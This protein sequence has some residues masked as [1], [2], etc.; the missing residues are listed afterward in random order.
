MEENSDL[1]SGINLC[2]PNILSLS[3]NGGGHQLIAVLFAD[4]IRGLEK[5]GGTVAPRHSLPYCLG[6]KCALNSPC[7]SCFVR[8]MIRANMPRMV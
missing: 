1:R 5:D 8:L 3:E 4:E 7:D 2:L 6:G